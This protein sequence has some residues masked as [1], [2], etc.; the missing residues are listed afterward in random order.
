MECHEAVI[1]AGMLVLSLPAAAPALA[2]GGGRYGLELIAGGL[3]FLVLGLLL[4]SRWLVAG[5]VLTLSGVALRW[6]ALIGSEAPYWLTLGAVGMALLAAGLLLLFER[7]QWDRT[8]TRI[9]R[10]WLAGT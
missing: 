9:G 3:A 2:P 8:R 6:L 5:G 1:A 10:W 4:S 7:D